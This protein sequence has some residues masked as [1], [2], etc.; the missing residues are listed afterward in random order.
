MTDTSQYI[1]SDRVARMGEGAQLVLSLCINA[2]TIDGPVA[3]VN[4]HEN[5]LEYFSIAHALDAINTYYSKLSDLGQRNADEALAVLRDRY[6][7]FDR[8]GRPVWMSVPA[9]EEGN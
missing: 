6:S 9:N 8:L 5:T 3:I 4:E 7:G 2:A 1:G